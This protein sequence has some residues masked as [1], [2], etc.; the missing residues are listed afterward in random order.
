MRLHV[1][2]LH[3]SGL[4]AILVLTGVWGALAV[5]GLSFHSIN[6]SFYS[7]HSP[8]D[9]RIPAFFTCFN[10]R[11]RGD[12]NWAMIA[13]NDLLP[14]MISKF[15]D[16]ALFRYIRGILLGAYEVIQVLFINL[17]GQSRSSRSMI[18]ILSQSSLSTWVSLLPRYG[19]A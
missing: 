12:K 16:L 6:M 4:I 1:H 10:C 3:I 11:I 14:N 13:V 9:R 18:R 5:P 17:G 8:K 15:N 2:I 19:K 7:F